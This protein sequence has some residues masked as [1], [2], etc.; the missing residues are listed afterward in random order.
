MAYHTDSNHILP[1]LRRQQK[2][3]IIRRIVLR[4]YKYL[5]IQTVIAS[6]L[7]ELFEHML[8]G[9]NLLAEVRRAHKGRVGEG[10]S[11]CS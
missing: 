6:R 3:R 11:Y 8:L 1:V 5:C 2:R 10:R 7:R 9:G 4:N